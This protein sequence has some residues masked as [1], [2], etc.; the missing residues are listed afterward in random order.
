MFWFRKSRLDD[1]LIDIPVFV[2]LFN[3]EP[4]TLLIFSLREEAKST[5][6]N[7][8]PLFPLAC[9][10]QITYNHSASFFARKPSKLADQSRAHIPVFYFHCSQSLCY[11]ETCSKYSYSEI[12]FP[13]CTLVAVLW[14]F[15]L[16]WLYGHMLPVVFCIMVL[17]RLR[18]H[19]GDNWT[20]YLT[21][22]NPNPPSQQATVGM[23]FRIIFNQAFSNFVT[24][25]NIPSHVQL[26]TYFPLVLAF[27]LLAWED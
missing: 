20:A 14:L 4:P 24:Y 10:S 1:C 12:S 23:L 17:G 26:P 9:K 19:W 8:R 16:K 15:I 13:G 18:A 6:L 2:L 3:S 27:H 22:T 21:S 7:K 25:T 11:D 5:A